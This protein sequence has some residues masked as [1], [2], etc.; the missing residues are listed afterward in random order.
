[1]R[2]LPPLTA[3]PAF[4][5]VARL[6]SVTAAAAELGRTHGAVS[7]QIRH[8]ADDLG[9]ALFEREGVGLRL[10]E[11]GARLQALVR[12]AL[13]DLEAEAQ[14]L[15]AEASEHLVEIGVSATLAMRWLMPRMP[16]FYA[17][18]P[19]AEVRLRMT[20]AERLSDS[21][22]DAVLSWDRLRGPVEKG[23]VR[24][25]GDAAYGLVHAPGY[26]LQRD[27]D[28]LR[29]PVRLWQPASPRAWETWERLSG[30]VLS[31]DHDAEHAHMFL[32]LE[33]AA[34]G[35]GVA[36]AERRLVDG[37]LATGRLVAPLGFERLAGG[38]VAVITERGRRR[39]SAAA[40][41]DW[42]ADEAS[43]APT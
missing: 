11:R 6:G 42:V 18:R 14:A 39:P 10:T 36:L 9:V 32:A 35:L 16:R 37:D 26:P 33:A 3:L 17:A 24:A 28:R 7:K 29:A 20:G 21:D 19:G 12:P 2:R 15:R 41:L 43:A 25:L 30:V 27:G 40:F 8:L 5:A 31:A 23:G 34:A 38:F 4:E 22:V 13:E 1:M